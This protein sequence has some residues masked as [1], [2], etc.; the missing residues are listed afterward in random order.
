MASRW[1]N[2]RWALIAPA[3]AMLCAATF[4]PIAAVLVLSTLHYDIAFPDKISFVGLDNF[5]RLISD[6]RFLNSVGVTL[7]LV[8][9]PVGLQ[10]LCGL[11]LA[12]ALK[13]KL[14]ATRWMRAAFLLPSVVPPAVG[15]ILWKLFLIPG[16]G[17]LSY[18]ASLSGVHLQADLLGSRASALAA[19]I[20]VSVWFGV[21][22][23]ALL[24]LSS[25]ESIPDDVYEAASIDGASWLQAQWCISIPLVLPA[26]GTVAVFQALEVLGIFPVIFVL[27]G[28]GPAGATEPLNYYAFLTGFTY[29][30]F[31]Y[32]AALLVVFTCT[33][34][35]ACFWS[36]RRISAGRVGS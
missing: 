25:L 24:L 20:L 5:K 35:C 12:I 4:I 22:I 21:P 18:L 33:L 14:I 10:L 1:L 23:V 16:V 19:V 26:M 17:G 6:S 2:E 34:V 7:M 15:G 36:I 8:V 11:G 13:E 30:D 9:I 32:S 27:T 3:I 28:G 31:D 29:L